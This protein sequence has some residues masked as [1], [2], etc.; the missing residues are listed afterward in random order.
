[1]LVHLLGILDLAAASIMVAGHY[2]L[3]KIPLIY[4]A[5]FLLTKLFFWR[6]WLSFMD[7]FAGVYC[8][9]IFFGASSGFVWFF[10][11]YFVYKTSVWLFYTMAN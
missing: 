5:I 6:D 2:E 4:A 1:M 11:V 3:L 8:L 10:V 7:A 9:F